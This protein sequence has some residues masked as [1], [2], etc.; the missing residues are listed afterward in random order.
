MHSCLGVASCLC[1][2]VANPLFSSLPG[3]SCSLFGLLDFGIRRSIASG[4]YLASR[5]AMV[6]TNVTDELLSMFDRA[7]NVAVLTGA[8]ISAESGVP[9][10]RGGGDSDIWTWRGRPVTELSSA[11]LIATDPKLVWEWFDYRR[12]MLSSIEAYTGHHAPA[13]LGSKVGSLTLGDPKI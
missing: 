3:L 5:I 11:E 10:F 8:G 9:T 6:L 12:G 2:L 13:G 4:F 1:V 7:R